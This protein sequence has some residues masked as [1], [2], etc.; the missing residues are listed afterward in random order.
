MFMPD[1]GEGEVRKTNLDLMEIDDL[2]KFDIKNSDSEEE[3]AIAKEKEIKK[4]RE[5]EERRK[6]MYQMLNVVAPG[7]NLFN[8]VDQETGSNGFRYFSLDSLSLEKDFG[9]SRRGKLLGHGFTNDQLD[10][11][12]T[13]P[14]QFVRYLMPEAQSVLLC[15]KNDFRAI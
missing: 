13:D 3:E 14:V 1:K 11:I 4:K 7:I 12:L 5:V 8:V 6:A 15:D 10:A 9:Y 2:A